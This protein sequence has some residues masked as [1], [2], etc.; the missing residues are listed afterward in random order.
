[1]FIENG[2]GCASISPKGG[3]VA[4]YVFRDKHIIYPERPVGEKSRGG[5]PICFPFFGKPKESFE[6]IPQH[7]FLRHQLL[8]PSAQ[9]IVSAALMGCNIPQVAYPWSLSYGIGV[10]LDEKGSLSVKLGVKRLDDG[11]K[12]AAPINPG[13]HPYFSNLR[14]HSAKIGGR[15]ISDFPQKSVGIPMEHP[16]LI[17]MGEC[18][19][20]MELEG[21]SRD[22]YFTIWS[23]NPEKYFCVE[24]VLTHPSAFNVEG[25][26]AFLEI[27]E[28]LELGMTIKPIMD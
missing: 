28:T 15:E 17:N 27:G 20:E 24:P 18:Q 11:L 25:K 1:M 26:G 22:S 10:S 8:S 9:T 5:I 2:D 14:K 23:D 13:F 21:F 6:E 16:I 19:A 7:G 3:I 4:M 12:T